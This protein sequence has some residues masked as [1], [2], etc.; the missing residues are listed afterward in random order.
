[1]LRSLPLPK[2]REFTRE[3]VLA[4]F[5]NCWTLT[6]VLFASL[7]TTDAF[8]RQPYHQLRHPMM[9]YYGHPA[10]LYINKFR[11]AGLLEE[12]ID[13]FFEQ[14]RKRQR[15]FASRS[16]RLLRNAAMLG[17]CRHRACT[18]RALGRRDSQEPGRDA[19]TWRA[20]TAVRDGR[21]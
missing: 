6:E 15:R 2:T 14:V 5:D 20:P 4:Y 21:G 8:I 7:Q 1:M 19:S 18:Q 16:V 11:V 10:V 9:F 12:G 17:T 13:Q 3:S